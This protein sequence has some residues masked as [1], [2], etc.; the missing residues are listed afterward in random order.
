MQSVDVTVIA[1]TLA[2]T[3]TPLIA[4][5]PKQGVDPVMETCSEKLIV[6]WNDSGAAAIA[7]ENSTATP[8][9]SNGCKK[10]ASRRIPISN[11]VEWKSEM[12]RHVDSKR[13]WN[14]RATT[15]ACCESH[16]VGSQPSDDDGVGRLRR[17]TGLRRATGGPARHLELG[18]IEPEYQR[19]Q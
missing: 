17:P 11:E 10:R 8:T 5:V 14:C 16:T 12:L 18:F 19:R 7:G 6:A 13:R 9:S 3:P 1:P 15:S 4:P 2:A